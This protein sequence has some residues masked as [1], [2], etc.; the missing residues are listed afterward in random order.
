MSVEGEQRESAG[1]SSAEAEDEF[2]I[3]VASFTVVFQFKEMDE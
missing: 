1:R 3:I 2:L